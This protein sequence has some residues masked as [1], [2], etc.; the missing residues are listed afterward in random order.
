MDSMECVAGRI[1]GIFVRLILFSGL[2]YETYHKATKISTNYTN[3]LLLQEL[4]TYF[5]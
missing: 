2:V 4:I 5:V 3:L 1:S